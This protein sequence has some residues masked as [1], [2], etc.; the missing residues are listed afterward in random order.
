MF[1]LGSN[2]FALWWGV[3]KTIVDKANITEKKAEARL[4]KLEERAAEKNERASKEFSEFGLW[5]WG[6]GLVFCHWNFLWLIRKDIKMKEK[7]KRKKEQIKAKQNN[8]IR[9][10]NDKKERMWWPHPPICIS[11]VF[12]SKHSATSPNLSPIDLYCYCYF[13]LFSVLAPSVHNV[14]LIWE[15][16]LLLTFPVVS[17]SSRTVHFQHGSSE[18]RGCALSLLI[19]FT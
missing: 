10:N 18:G 17:R 14:C 15:P 19:C 9:N 12:G 16:I 2:G 3:L 13:S 6:T 5:V 8:A 11:C 4:V 7:M 1:P